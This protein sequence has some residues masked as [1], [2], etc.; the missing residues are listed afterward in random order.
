MDSPPPQRKA[1]EAFTFWTWHNLLLGDATVA[2]Y[3]HLGTA[4]MLHLTVCNLRTTCRNCMSR[5]CRREAA[6]FIPP[7]GLGSPVQV[8]AAV[9]QALM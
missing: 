3:D 9:V 2:K 6:G 7:P 5:A 1:P 8:G 4:P